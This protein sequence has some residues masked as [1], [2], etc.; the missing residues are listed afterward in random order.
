M[1]AKIVA[2]LGSLEPSDVTVQL[3]VAPNLGEAR[4][5]ATRF[6]EWRGGVARYSVQVPQ[7]T[8]T[9]A[10]LVARVLPCHPALADPCVPNLITWSD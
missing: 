2:D 8:G 6:E 5:L 7:E 10:D 1:R 4:P 9:D 3:W